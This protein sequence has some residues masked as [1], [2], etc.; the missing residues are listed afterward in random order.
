MTLKLVCIIARGT[1]FPPILV[2]LRRFVFDLS[3]AS[4]DLATLTFEV[5]ELVGDAG[6]RASSVSQV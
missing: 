5:T 2:F 6:L 1:T 3:D 4:R